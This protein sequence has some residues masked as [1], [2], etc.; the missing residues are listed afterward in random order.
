MNVYN[1]DDYIDT[2]KFINGC[3]RWVNMN[4]KDLPNME[5]ITGLAKFLIDTWRESKCP[6]FE[7]CTKCKYNEFCE[8]VVDLS[9][10]VNKW[11]FITFGTC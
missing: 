5:S 10:V 7:K 4:S 3:E 8:I 9:K 1:V 6:D 2:A 11:V